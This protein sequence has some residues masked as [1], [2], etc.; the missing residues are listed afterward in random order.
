MNLFCRALACLDAHDLHVE[1]F[2]RTQLCLEG[3]QKLAQATRFSNA[4]AHNKIG[5]DVVS[6]ETAY[7]FHS[8]SCVPLLLF[9][10]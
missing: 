6:S 4:L 5:Q 9:S 3:E 8:I 2:R 7:L 1:V 10:T